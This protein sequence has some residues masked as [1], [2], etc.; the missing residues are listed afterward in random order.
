MDN[1]RIN[2]VYQSMAQEIINERP[3]L[4]E[5]RN[6]DIQII[7]LS[8]EHAKKTADKKVT[9]A[10]MDGLSIYNNIHMM[11]DSQILQSQYLNPTLQDLQT[12]RFESFYSMS[13]YMSAMISKR[14]VNLSSRMISR[15]SSSLWTSLGRTGQKSTAPTIYRTRIGIR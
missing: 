1:R 8:S 4:E 3:E 2:D 5:L 13:C 7:C 11:A 12:T 6:A 14:I 10:L 15:I 9:K